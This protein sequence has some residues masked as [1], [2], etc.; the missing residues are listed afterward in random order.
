LQGLI[1]GAENIGV[2]QHNTDEKQFEVRKHIEEMWK[3]ISMLTGIKLQ[4]NL[5]SI[6]SLWIC[7]KTNQVPNIVHAAALWSL[8][9]FRNDLCFNGS[10]WSCM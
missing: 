2:N 8:W 9:K 6:S 4:V 7:E 1:A 5:L 10:G 3:Q